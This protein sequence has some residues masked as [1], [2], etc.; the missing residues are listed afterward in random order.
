MTQEKTTGPMKLGFVEGKGFCGEGETGLCGGVASPR[1]EAEEEE[2]FLV[3]N[4]RELDGSVRVASQ[5][6]YRKSLS[7]GQDLAQKGEKQ[8]F[9]QTTSLH[10]FANPDVI[11]HHY[12]VDIKYEDGQ[13]ADQRG[14]GRKVMEKLQEIYASDLKNVNFAYDGEKSLFTVGALQ[15][16]RDVF[17]VVIEDVSSARTTARRT[18]GGNGSP[19]GSDLKRMKRPMWTKTF[20]VELSLV[21]KFPMCAIIKVLGGQESDSY[22][23]VIRVLDIILRQNSAKQGCLLVRQSFF[24]DCPRDFIKLG[25]GVVGCPGY[26]SSFRPTQSGLSL[27]IDLSTMMIVKPGPVIDFLLSNQN[28][29]DPR[30]IDWRKAKRALKNLRIKTTHTKSEFKIDGLSEKSCYEQ[31]FSMKQRNGNGSGTVEVTVYN[32]Y[33]QQWD[34][35]LKE[36]ASSPC[37][38]VGKPSRPTYIP[39]ELCLLVSLQR[40]KK[41]LTVLQRSSLVQNSRKNPSERKSLF[42]SALRHTNYNSDDMLKKCGVSIAPEFAQVDAR[43]LQPPKFQAGGGQDIFVNNG[44]WNFNKN[45]F[46]GAITLNQWAVVNF[47]AP[48]NV[49][50]LAQ[51]IIRCGNAKGMVDLQQINR[52]DAVIQEKHEMIRAP[53]PNRVDAMF[54]QIMARFPDEPPK[55][56]LCILPEKK[57]SDICGPWKWNCLVKYG[58]RTQCLAPPNKNINDQYLT[59]VLLKINAKLGGLNSILQTEDTGTIP[60]VSRTPTIIFGMDVSHGLPGSNVPSIAAVVSSL[61]WPRVSRYRASVCTQTAGQGMI[62]SLFKPE[63]NVDHGIIRELI[64]DFMKC[65]NEDF[66]NRDNHL[67]E[68]IIIFS[69][70]ITLLPRDGVSEGQ[71]TQ[72]LN[73]ELAQIIEACKSIK[74]TWL[75]KFT[76]IV[77]QKNHHTRFFQPKGNRDDTNVANVPAGTV[78]DKGI[79]HPRNYDFYMCAHAGMI[80]TTR[81]THYHVLHDEIGFSPDQLQELVHSL[82]YVYQRSTSAISVVAPVYYAH[83]AAA[84]VRQF[85][86]LDETSETASSASGGSAPMPELPRLHK[87]VRSSMFFC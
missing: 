49:Q 17:T 53:A 44:R 64:G 39:I 27:N 40:Y 83:L 34:I 15:N 14:I 9:L 82:S 31:T 35:K 19:E 6:F 51:R 11:F 72:V 42:S 66:K 68:Q 78:V 58:I 55:F 12:H 56:L 2:G 65:L 59:N 75:P 28:I 23:D 73:I 7:P 70:D 13:P 18:P 10:Q 47:S 4:V 32:Y 74:D 30:R 46:F 29:S 24:H 63:G 48:C 81:P 76:V 20:K 87:N 38:N 5:Q 80:G 26:H 79:C 41:A 54:Q 67:P 21:A 45:S 71:F 77:A 16:A 52:E 22:L 62:G 84:Q 37:L 1:R 61:G 25:G 85:F 69:N 50:D 60:L 36:S 3:C 33:L 8:G 43:I 57:N 86:R